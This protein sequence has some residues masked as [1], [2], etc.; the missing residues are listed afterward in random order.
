MGII[1]NAKTPWVLYCWIFEKTSSPW[2]VLKAFWGAKA[3]GTCFKW[4][5]Y[6]PESTFPSLNH[7]LK[8]GWRDLWIAMTLCKG[9]GTLQLFFRWHWM[10][11]I[12]N[13]PMWTCFSVAVR[14]PIRDIYLLTVQFDLSIRAWILV[15]RANHQMCLTLAS[16]RLYCPLA[17]S[18]NLILLPLVLVIWN[19]IWS[20]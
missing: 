3:W 11:L 19:A 16:M 9:S 6:W 15:W 13:Q 5:S 7:H 4:W 12:C 14:K 8:C 2:C 20:L 1:F 18:W 10:C 17:L